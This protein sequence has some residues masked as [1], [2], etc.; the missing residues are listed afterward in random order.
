M[1]K[2]ILGLLVLVVLLMYGC[3]QPTTGPLV[4]EPS[5][6]VSV[7]EEPSVMEIS[8]TAKQWEFIPNP[9]EV[10]KGAK[11]ILKMK[12][13]DVPHGF[14]LPEFGINERLDPGKE[15]VVEFVADRS[16]EF[17][18]FCN[19]FCGRGHSRMKGKLIVR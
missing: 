18:F 19:V 10:N 7:V 8:V 12:S 6:E 15:V 16:G 4:E 9:I 11:V 1:K 13:V 17:E 5:E 14:I 3:A 2:Y